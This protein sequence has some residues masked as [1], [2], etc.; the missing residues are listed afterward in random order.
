MG[1]RAIY[2]F[3]SIVAVLLCMFFA[4]AMADC[5]IS[6]QSGTMAK[7][8]AFETSECIYRYISIHLNAKVSNIDVSRSCISIKCKD[9]CVCFLRRSVLLLSDLTV[10]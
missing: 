4:T 10:I 6:T 2:T 5:L 9:K 1:P 7:L 3:G 8:L